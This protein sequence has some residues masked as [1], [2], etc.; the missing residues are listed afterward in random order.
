MACAVGQRIRSPPPFRPNPGERRSFC[1]EESGG[2]VR[3]CQ[4]EP[5]FGS[6]FRPE[7]W[8]K[9]CTQRLHSNDQTERGKGRDHVRTRSGE[10]AKGVRNRLALNSRLLIRRERR[11]GAEGPSMSR[12]VLSDF[13]GFWQPT[14]CLDKDMSFFQIIGYAA[15]PIFRLKRGA[16]V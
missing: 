4:G 11:G 8:R 12:R 5:D 13:Q 1:R 7:G 10:G 14:G 16:K 9:I 3:R 2:R 15:P 6:E